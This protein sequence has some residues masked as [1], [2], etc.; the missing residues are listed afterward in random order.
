MYHRRRVT[1]AAVLAV[2]AVTLIPVALEPAAGAAPKP[3]V[4]VELADIA[5]LAADGQT[6]TIEV[7]ASCARP[8]QVLEA[9]VTVSQPQADG[10]GGFPLTCTGRPQVFAVAVTSLDQPFTLGDAQAS[11]LVLVERRDDTRE[12]QDTEVVRIV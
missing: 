10:M 9:F 4:S 6:V 5:A 7:T 2:V 1:T 12:A 8:W 11:A 3:R